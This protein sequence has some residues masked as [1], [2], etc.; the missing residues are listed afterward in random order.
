MKFR[1]SLLKTLAILGPMAIALSAYATGPAHADEWCSSYYYDPN[2]VYPYDYPYPSGDFFFFGDDHRFH[3][4]FDHYGDHHFDR[5]GPRYD[6]APH[7][8][9]RFDHGGFDHGGFAGG[10]PGA[11]MFV[12]GGGGHSG[13][14]HGGGGHGR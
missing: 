12:P 2:C 1:R 13:G 4:R 9:G 8:P 3:H 5:H 6:G 7:G 10:R 14:G 11:G